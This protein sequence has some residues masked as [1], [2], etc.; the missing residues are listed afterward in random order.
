MAKTMTQAQAMQRVEMVKVWGDDLRM[1]EYCCKSGTPYI[2]SGDEFI[3]I[4][5]PEIKT[6][7]C[8]GYQT[9]YSGHEYDD[10]EKLRERCANSVDY[11]RRKN[12]EQ[13]TGTL[14]RLKD[15]SKKAYKQIHYQ[16]GEKQMSI[17]IP[18]NRDA[19][20]RMGGANELTE[21]TESERAAVVAA[22]ETELSKLNKRLDS[23]LKRYGLSKL[24]TWTYWQD[25]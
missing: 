13:L 19:Y 4:D 9:N 17:K 1:V 10:A 23:Y 5:K 6:R 8:F 18:C 16:R 24:K 22:Y 7:F 25:A 14:E 20:E 2:L 3:V 11:F 21:L 15:A 12:T